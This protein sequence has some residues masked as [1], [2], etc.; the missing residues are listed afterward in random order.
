MLRSIGL[1]RGDRAVAR[2]YFYTTHPMSYYGD[3]RVSAD[4]VGLAR[5][6]RDAEEPGHAA[7]L[8]H[9]LCRNM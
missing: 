8:S 5:A 9:R 1:F 3:G 6:R 7:C 2:L 4:F